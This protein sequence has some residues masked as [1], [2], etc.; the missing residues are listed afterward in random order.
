[1]NTTKEQW[2][3]RF[4][5][6]MAAAG[7]AIGLGNLWKFPYVAGT[8]GGAVFLLLYIIFLLLLGIPILL[9]ELAIGR[10]GGMN[11]IDSCKKINPKWGFAGAFGIAGAFGVMSSY[12][13]VGGWVIR[14]IINSFADGGANMNAEYF[15]EFSSR[16]FEPI[17]WTFVFMAA[18]CFIVAGGVTKGIERVSSVLLPILIVFLFGIMIYS[19]TLPGALKGV[20]FF[21]VP[22]FS[23]IGGFSGFIRIA[24]NAMGQV[25]FSLSLGMGTLITY[26]SYL[27][28]DSKLVSSTVTII[29]M[30]TAIALAAGFAILPAVFSFGLEPDGGFGLI[31]QTLPVVFSRMKGGSF[32]AA[33]F[34]VLVLFAALTS[35]I[36]L[37]EVIVAWVCAKTKLTRT[38]AA[39]I[40]SVLIFAVGC[41]ASLSVGAIP[42]LSVGGMTLFELFSFLSDK[43]I[44][45]LGGFF[46]C[47]L[48]GW[49]WG[50]PKASEE[51]SNSGTIGFR[52]R[53]LYSVTVRYIAPMLIA[54]IFIT[55]IFGGK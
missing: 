21:I 53:K 15:S 32:V 27:P 16:G 7:S 35:S 26:G 20:K 54:V 10:S 6:I 5:F 38:W 8:N 28:K 55:S 51:I 39:V 3:S 31:F 11:A 44:M 2:S 40:V 29:A 52:A 24:L 33:A 9:S 13:V 50:I 22:K 48:T 30:D 14:Y 1:M 19:L 47:L 17:L 4:G 43:I 49:V 12:C 46:I 34:F 41:L 37:L 45:P 36:S 42:E 18:T 25:F 23:E